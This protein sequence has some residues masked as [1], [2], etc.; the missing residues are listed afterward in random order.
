M[1]EYDDDEQ[2]NAYE[3][4]MGF[5]PATFIEFASIIQNYDDTARPV[6]DDIDFEAGDFDSVEYDFDGEPVTLY[7]I[8]IYNFTSRFGE[9][10]DVD[11]YDPL[12]DRDFGDDEYYEYEHPK[13]FSFP[14]YN[15]LRGACKR[16]RADQN[17]GRHFRYPPV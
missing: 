17:Y 9:L 11:D 5:D 14:L 10:E 6:H 2:H 12:Y 1:S 3:R 15:P 16:L 7:G 4:A 8:V 13:P